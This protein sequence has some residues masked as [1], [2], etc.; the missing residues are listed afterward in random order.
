MSATLKV[1]VYNDQIGA[2]SPEQVEKINNGEYPIHFATNGAYEYK[3]VAESELE[4]YTNYDATDEDL[5]AITELHGY[6]P[7]VYNGIDTGGVAHKVL[8]HAP[9]NTETVDEETI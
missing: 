3:F 9:E 6:A 8:N 7:V 1:S 4:S 2:F 5:A